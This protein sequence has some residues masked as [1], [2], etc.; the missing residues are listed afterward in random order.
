MESVVIDRPIRVLV[1]VTEQFKEKLQRQA[2]SEISRIDSELEQL[3][4]QRKRW[5]SEVAKTDPKQMENL[6]ESLDREQS[7]REQ[8]KME[9]QAQLRQADELENGELVQQGTVEAQVEVSRGD[10][11]DEIMNTLIIVED[12]QVVEIR[13][14]AHQG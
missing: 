6:R 1:R 13:N 7:S 2:E 14:G 9:L 12:G 3:Q 10:S 5:M 4:F 8:R 11:W